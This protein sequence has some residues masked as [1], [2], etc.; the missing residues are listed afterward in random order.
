LTIKNDHAETL[1]GLLRKA[2]L[3]VDEV[4]APGAA[5]YVC[6]PMGA[7]SVVFRGR[8]IGQGWRLHETLVWVTITPGTRR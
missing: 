1:D 5:L 3:A 4:L 2:F 6:E 7:N 8:F